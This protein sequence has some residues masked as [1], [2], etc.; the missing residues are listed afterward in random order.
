MFV[1]QT[2]SQSHIWDVIYTVPPS[3]PSL[4]ASC[5]FLSFRF[6][7][8]GIFPWLNPPLLQTAKISLMDYFQTVTF[9]FKLYNEISIFPIDCEI[10]SVSFYNC[11][12]T[13][14]T[15]SWRNRVR[16][17]HWSSANE[18]WLSLVERRQLYNTIKN[19]SGHSGT[20]GSFPAPRSFFMA[21]VASMNRKVLS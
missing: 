1:F 7:F 5:N 20:N 17:S 14:G 8:L 18:A 9:S 2:T 10:V 12:E 19:P 13:T 3:L 6:K 16:Y 21:Q 4:P 15:G 11:Q